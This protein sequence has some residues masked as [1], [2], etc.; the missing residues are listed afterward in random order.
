[1]MLIIVGT[2]RVEF[3]R[4]KRKD[5]DRHFVTTRGQLYKLYPDGLTRCIVTKHGKHAKD[6]EI[7]VYKEN[8]IQPYHARRQLYT[9]TKIL[10]E[11]DNHKNSIPK[12]KWKA[13]IGTVG[14]VASAWKQI[15]P[16]VPFIIA[17]LVLLWALVFA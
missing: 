6:E 11:I 4:V 12:D 1:M 14:E 16:M 10:S 8:A 9:M 17:G 5:F 15:S 7:I 13:N 3:V 2:N